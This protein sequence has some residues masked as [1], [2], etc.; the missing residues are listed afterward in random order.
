MRSALRVVSRYRPRLLTLF[1]LA[2]VAVPGTLA[3]LSFD[4]REPPPQFQEYLP[5][6]TIW[7]KSE[8][9]AY[10]WPLTWRGCL[11]IL[12][13]P[14]F[15]TIG[16]YYSAGRLA[17]NVML[18]ALMLTLPAG[19]CEWLLRRYRPRPRWSLRTMLAI[20]AL[21]AACC[22]W[23][24]AARQRAKMQEPLVAEINR[25]DGRV[26]FERWGPKWLDLLGADR[27]RRHLVGVSLGDRDYGLGIHDN[28]EILLRRLADLP[29]LRYLSFRV[30]D[31]L[32]PGMASAVGEMRRLRYLR[33]YPEILGDSSADAARRWQEGLREISKLT[34]LEELCLDRL[35][36]EEGGLAALAGLANL[37]SLALTDCLLE[38][39]TDGG[40][41]VQGFPALP[42]LES[43]DLASCCDVCDE[44]LRHLR[45]LNALKSL[46]LSSVFLT[47]NGWGE[48][49][50]LETLEEISIDEPLDDEL[51]WSGLLDSL[52][53]VKRLKTLHLVVYGWRLDGASASVAALP[54]DGGDELLVLKR[55]HPEATNLAL[56]RLRKAHPGITIDSQDVDVASGEEIPWEPYVADDFYRELQPMPPPFNVDGVLGWNW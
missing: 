13:P 43:L 2:V 28:D 48:L 19:L 46:K 36:I 53:S 54:L 23:I 40:C 8:Q 29:C 32:T 11:L 26:V 24:A 37:R 44:D 18:W 45:V 47:R 16:W 25:R 4:V 38:R 21:V 7:N 12:S 49:R 41:L 3:N 22:G 1:V 5:Q 55:R 42:R 35:L 9:M 10:G 56:Q 20:V 39:L 31:R 51:T 14:S 34:Q 17:A 15:G 33:V 52:R 30:D 6:N 50:H 27:F